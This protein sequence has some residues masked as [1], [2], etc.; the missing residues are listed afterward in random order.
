MIVYYNI[1]LYYTKLLFSHFT[2]I[3]IYTI[4]TV[5]ELRAYIDVIRIM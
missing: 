5:W 4:C 1:V 2:M 3:Y